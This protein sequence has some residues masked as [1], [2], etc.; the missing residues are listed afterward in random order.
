MSETTYYKRNRET[1]LNRA[2]KYY[3]DDKERLRE[4]AKNK[5]RKLSQEGKNIKREYGRNRYKN[6]PDKKK[7]TKRIPKNHH[8]KKNQLQKL[9]CTSLHC[10]K[11][12]QKV[13]IF[14]E[15]FII[16]NSFHKNQKPISI[17]KVEIKRIVLSK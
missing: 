8:N 16:K 10:I 1:I 7:Q 15:D 3:K 14:G 9:H 6:M 12:E 17:D 11:M 13:L 2:K 4:Q 5:Y